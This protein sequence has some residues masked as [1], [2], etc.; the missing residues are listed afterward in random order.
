MRHGS[1]TRP[2]HLGAIR[3]NRLIQRVQDD[4]TSR[5]LR[6]LDAPEAVVGRLGDNLCEG[7]GGFQ[8]LAEPRTAGSRRVSAVRRSGRTTQW[9]HLDWAWWKPPRSWCRTARSICCHVLAQPV[10]HKEHSPHANERDRLPPGGHVSNRGAGPPNNRLTITDLLRSN[11]NRRDTS[12][13]L[14]GR[15]PLFLQTP[16]IQA[17][18]LHRNRRP[19]PVLSNSVNQCTSILPVKCNRTVNVV[20]HRIQQARILLL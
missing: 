10:R 9:R 13:R 4:R 5:R 1:R 20:V 17:Q 7:P 3:P 8:A 2:T 6:R 19:L 16:S 12:K 15:S 18:Y 14:Q 11:H